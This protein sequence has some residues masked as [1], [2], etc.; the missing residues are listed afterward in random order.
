M[1]FFTEVIITPFLLLMLFILYAPKSIKNVISEVLPVSFLNQSK[2]FNYLMRN[3]IFRRYWNANW[4]VSLNG[5][6]AS[7]I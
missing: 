2:Y 3:K 6:N 1:K 5:V 4:E 7:K